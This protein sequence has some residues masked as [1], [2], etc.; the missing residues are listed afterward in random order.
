MVPAYFIFIFQKVIRWSDVLLSLPEQR[1]LW[2]SHPPAILTPDALTPRSSKCVLHSH[3]ASRIPNNFLTNHRKPKQNAQSMHTGVVCSQK[4]CWLTSK[5]W[6]QAL[7][8]S[9]LLRIKVA[10]SRLGQQSSL[11]FHKSPLPALMFLLS[12]QMLPLPTGCQLPLL[13]HP[14]NPFS[15]AQCRHNFH[16]GTIQAYLS[17]CVVIQLDSYHLSLQ[18]LKLHSSCYFI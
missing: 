17:L 7:S 10:A 16:Q 9:Q 15:N 5:I 12:S 6:A 13:H 11:L 18:K 14:L 1:D 4:P 3:A 2:L 8:C